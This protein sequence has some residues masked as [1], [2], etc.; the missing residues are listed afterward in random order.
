MMQEYIEVESVDINLSGIVCTKITG[1]FIV[2]KCL[3]KTEKLMLIDI[4]EKL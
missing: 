1:L 4:Q 2:V 3:Y